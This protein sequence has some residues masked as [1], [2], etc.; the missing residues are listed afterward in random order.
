[1]SDSFWP[2]GPTRLLCP[3]DSPGKSIGVGCHF[4]L[5]GIF[6]VQGWNLGLPHCRQML[7]LWATREALLMY[8]YTYLYLSINN[9]YIK[10]LKVKV[11]I[12]IQS[13]FSWG[14]CSWV[15]LIYLFQTDQETLQLY[16][17]TLKPFS[18]YACSHAVSWR[19]LK[20]KDIS[21]LYNI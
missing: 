18:S 1:M 8:T 9:N 21:G 10:R 14:T 20:I 15:F 6:P 11:S 7:T 12:P 4:L 16:P 17:L 5:Q 19:I 3:W 2:H 13:L